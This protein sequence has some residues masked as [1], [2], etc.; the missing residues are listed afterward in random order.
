MDINRDELRRRLRSLD[1]AQKDA[2]PL[3]ATL[4]EAIMEELPAAERGRFLLGDMDR[5]GFLRLGG[6]TVATTA[7][8][9]ACRNKKP[10]AQIPIDGSNP[11]YSAPKDEPV[12]DIVLLRTATSLELSIVDAYTKMLESNYVSDSAITDLFKVFSDHHSKHAEFLAAATTSA[13]GTACTTL[14]PKIT[15]YL[16]APLLAQVAANTAGAGEDAKSLAYGLENLAQATYQGVVPVLSQP[17]LRKAAL[18]VGSIEAEHAAVLGAVL[19]P[20]NLVPP[21]ATAAAT[22]TG[23]TTTV[24]PTATTANIIFAVPAGF[25]SLAP[26]AITVGPANENGVRT[27]VNMETPSLNSYSYQAEAC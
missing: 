14:N 11:G 26:Y 17:S 23:S 21:A 4:T 12:D 5:R 10:A 15:S 7:V 3:Q 20:D 8:L 9:A 24:K 1:R 13:G 22:S 2:E 18:S 19:N 27:T 16:I 25:G 6:L